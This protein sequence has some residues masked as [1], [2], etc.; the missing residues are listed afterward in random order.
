MSLSESPEQKRGQNVLFGPG[1]R[2]GSG[3]DGQRLGRRVHQRKLH[4]RLHRPLES[5]T[6]RRRRDHRLLGGQG[7]AGHVQSAD[8]RHAQSRHTAGLP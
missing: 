4:G 8:R 3:A 7:L 5:G 2:Q 6:R 1:G